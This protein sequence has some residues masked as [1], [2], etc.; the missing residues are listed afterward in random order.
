MLLAASTVGA[1][2]G[3]GVEMQNRAL[4]LRMPLVMA[5][6]L[7]MAPAALAVTIDWVPIG[8]PDNANDATGH[9]AVSYAY[10]VSKY[11]VT[12]SQ[13]AEF[14]NAKAASDSLYLYHSYMGSDSI[15]GGITRNGGPGSYSYTVKPGFADKPVTYVSF[16]D[17]LRFANWLHNGQGTGDTETGA[18]TL[19]GGTETPSNGSTVTRNPEAS[20]FLTSQNE[21]YKAA[22]YDALTTSYFAYP[23][24]T[25]TQTECAA[26][27]P[28]TNRA[29]CDFAVV[30][31]TPVGAYTGSAS[32]Y[33]TFDQAG[34]LWEW[35]EAIIFELQRG[36]RGGSWQ[37]AAETLAAAY[38]TIEPDASFAND[39]IGFPGRDDSRARH[40]PARDYGPTW[41]CIPA[42][43]SGQAPQE[44]TSSS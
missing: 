31:P 33:G 41:A 25:N 5:A 29:N 11:E 20:I 3:E 13:Y 42:K 26:P 36:M 40:G 38:G 24:G 7:V 21:W 27:T 16:Y 39:I 19:L 35:T 15:A 22:Y 30:G 4:S 14:L 12:N 28:V 18:Y 10:Y 32:P 2:H 34:N 23:A 37:N 43:T 9:G 44:S 1:P 17:S 8:N 6:L